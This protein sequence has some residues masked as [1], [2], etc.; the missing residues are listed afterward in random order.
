MSRS[1]AEMVAERIDQEILSRSADWVAEQLQR[2][3]LARIGFEPRDGTHY[4]ITIIHERCPGSSNGTD[5]SAGETWRSGRF[6]VSV[7]H[8]KTYPWE[9]WTLHSDYVAEKWDLRLWDAEV[10]T[11]FL[12]AVSARLPEGWRS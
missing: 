8:G 4:G 9:G 1:V 6:L 11:A 2:L 10:V 3:G 5:G 7:D 12:C